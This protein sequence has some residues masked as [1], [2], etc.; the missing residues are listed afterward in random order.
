MNGDNGYK[1]NI[2]WT[3]PIPTSLITEVT[4][5]RDSREAVGVTYTNLAGQVSD[6][7]FTGVNIVVTRYD[8]G[9]TRTDKVIR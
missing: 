3:A 1:F 4:D 6:K 2:R 5:L 7:P 9:S 8:D